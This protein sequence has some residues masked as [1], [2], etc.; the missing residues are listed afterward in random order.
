M[1]RPP[2]RRYVVSGEKSKFRECMDCTWWTG[3]KCG[4]GDLRQDH[5]D[6]R[7]CD[8]FIRDSLRYAFFIKV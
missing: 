7:G 6:R 5:Q 4:V 3:R 1:L 8:L 2:Q